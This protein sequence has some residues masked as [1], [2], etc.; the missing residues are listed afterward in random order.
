MNVSNWFFR[1]GVLAVLVGMCLGMWMGKEE[2]FT[3]AP[4]HAH[5]NLVGFVLPFLFGFFYRSFPSVAGGL[6]AK[7]HLLLSLLGVVSMTGALAVFLQ[8]DKSAVPVMLGGELA[9]ALG[10]LIFAV[11]VWR[12]VGQSPAPAAAE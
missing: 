10:M 11:N 3:L 9:T 12:A 7:A 1:F 6:S 4:V 2:N 8:G 5:L